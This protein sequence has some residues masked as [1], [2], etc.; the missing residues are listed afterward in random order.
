MADLSARTDPEAAVTASTTPDATQMAPEESSPPT[1]ASA[2]K[3]TLEQVTKRFGAE[4]VTP[5]LADIDLRVGRN[6]FVSVVGRSGCGKTTLLKLLAGLLRP[7][8]GRVLVEGADVT[9]PGVDRG[10]VFQHSAL[11]PWLSAGANIDF[12]PKN[13]GVSKAR[14][15]ELT[16]DLVKLVRLEG[17]EDSYPHELSGGMQQRV[18]IA[19]ALAM[20]PAVLLMDEPFGAL[21]ELTRSEMQEELLRIW[22]ER[23]KTV[24]F[25]THSI[26]EALY[27][28]DRVVVLSPHPGRI[29]RVLDIDL[30]RP[31]ERSSP[32]FLAYYEQV[33]GE[34]F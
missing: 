26:F 21:D 33:H 3:I 29:R 8:E 18:A 13:A 12:G 19:R 24:V 10:L 23:T 9:G 32:E 20:D 14:R 17:F 6:E 5:A 34:I 7:S 2:E 16:A 25:I 11:F 30:P 27:L 31:R 22:E 28:S 4:D 1:G 15:R